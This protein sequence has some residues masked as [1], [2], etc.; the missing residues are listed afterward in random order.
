[1]VKCE[2]PRGTSC[3]LQAGR[4]RLARYFLRAEP[5]HFS[6]IHSPSRTLSSWETFQAWLCREACILAP[7]DPSGLPALS[8]RA[9][10]S[11]PSRARGRAAPEVLF[12][13]LLPSEEVIP[14]RI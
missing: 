9:P 5:R 13:Y 14:V 3:A 12:L 1:M 6:L 2:P 11:P 8:P 4:V 10:A 7:P